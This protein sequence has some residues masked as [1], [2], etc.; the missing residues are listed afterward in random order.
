MEDRIK[1]VERS[2]VLIA[3]H[4]INLESRLMFSYGLIAVLFLILIFSSVNRADA[5]ELN[6][7]VPDISS[8][9]EFDEFDENIYIQAKET[10]SRDYPDTP[11]VVFFEK[12][13]ND[14]GSRSYGV[15]C[16]VEK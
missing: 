4:I 3:K 8:V 15:I 11:C 6:C 9:T 14:D 1:K 10:C 2:L 7:P 5:A 12:E 13:E 16:G